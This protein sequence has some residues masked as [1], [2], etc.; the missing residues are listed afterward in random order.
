MKKNL[1]LCLLLVLT[2]CNFTNPFVPQE[3]PTPTPTAT[4]TPT[5][6]PT[7]TP[8]PTPGPN[9]PCDNPLVPLG[10]GNQWTYRVTTA[11]GET[12]YSLKSLENRE[13]AN[14]VAL[15]EY[16]DPKNNLSLQE[17]VVCQEGAIENLPLFVMN[18]LF[19]DYLSSYID[20]YHESGSYAPNYASLSQNNWITSWQADYLTETGAYVNNHMG[21]FDL[22]IPANTPVKLSFQVIGSSESVTTPAGE[23]AHAIEITQFFILN[24][25]IT[26]PGSGSGTSDT[27]T[28]HT[29]QWYEPYVGLV[30]ARVESASLSGGGSGYRVP[31]ESALELIDFSTGN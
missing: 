15:V 26:A 21:T 6:S 4:L 8:T 13:E 18:M 19:S 11:N 9:G 31:L 16:S 29:T 5:L 14:F 2:A 24:V 25:T 3:T 23:F 12:L 20:T 10:A 22:L 17:L 1:L 7:Q 30:R 28:L 27:L